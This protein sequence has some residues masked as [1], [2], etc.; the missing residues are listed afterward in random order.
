MKVPPSEKVA[1]YANCPDGT[2]N[3]LFTY[4]VHDLDHS[5]DLLNKFKAKGFEIKKAYHTFSNGKNMKLDALMPDIDG[6]TSGIYAN[7]RDL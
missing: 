1:F 7:R 3:K 4:L 6:D 2:K 5:T